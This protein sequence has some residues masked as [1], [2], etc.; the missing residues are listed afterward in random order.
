V[1]KIEPNE[2]Q[3]GDVIEY[4]ENDGGAKGYVLWDIVEADIYGRKQ[5]LKNM[6]EV[7]IN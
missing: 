2:Y 6:V 1:D 4:P 7:F 3:K 5:D